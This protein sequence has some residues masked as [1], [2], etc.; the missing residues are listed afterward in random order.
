MSLTRRRFSN[1]LIASPS[2]V[3]AAGNPARAK[4]DP[5]RLAR[6]GDRMKA[7]V[8]RGTTA[9]IVT[10]V[11]RHGEI[12]HL[13]ATGWADIENR[14]PM[15][16]DT[17]FQIASM[18]KPVTGVAV[19]IL[20]DEGKLG[21]SDPVEKHLPEFRGLWV[22]DRSAKDT[23]TLRRPARPITVRDLMTHTAGMAGDYPAALSDVMEKGDRT[24]AEVV[25]IAS[26]QPLE[27]Q[28]GTRWLSSNTGINTLGRIVEVIS[29]QPFEK[30]MESRIFQPLGM[31][32]SC[33]YPKPEQF[34]RIAVIYKR[35][36]GK[37]VP[38]AI[39]RF[40]KNY[41]F[42]RASGGMFSTAGDMAR[43]YQMSLN[44]GILD[45][46]RILSKS[47]VEVMTAVHTG[48]LPVGGSSD[49]AY[50]LTWRLVKGAG[51]TLAGQS[52]GTYGHGGAYGTHGWVDPAKHLA[53]VFM[54]Q[55]EGGGREESTVFTEMANAAVEG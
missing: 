20:A 19:A 42:T 4:M 46:K 55:R 5:A 52:I 23:V 22:A 11:E 14:R 13:E 24:L 9:G 48:D 1:L 25:L 2:L 51:A 8:E 12:A 47:A 38:S 53:G 7:F 45:G 10:L 49:V 27:F 28:P 37:L 30:F 15:R 17:I 18:T 43:F 40:R 3:A 29:D 54:I 39:D 41:R 32:D 50:G 35:E 16:A 31:K 34:D 6:I 33:F 44:G 26:Q 36:N 21:F